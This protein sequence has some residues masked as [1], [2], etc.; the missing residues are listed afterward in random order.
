MKKRNIFI[1]GFIL[2]LASCVRTPP[3]EAI[4]E[5]IT[6]FKA[7]VADR[8]PALQGRMV[9]QPFRSG[10]GVPANPEMDQASLMLVKSFTESVN[11]DPSQLT[12][13]TDDSLSDAQFFMKGYITQYKKASGLVDRWR[14]KKNIFAVEGKIIDLRSDRVV[15]SFSAAIHSSEELD[16]SQ[17]AR[18]VGERVAAYVAGQDQELP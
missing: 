5:T 2:F 10:A 13:I 6:S 12:V 3:K 4:P 9:I 15:V 18:K 1:I 7:Q 16:L 14:K 11:Q 17:L 8:A